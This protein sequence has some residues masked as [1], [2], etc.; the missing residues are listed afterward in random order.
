MLS[1]LK[2]NKAKPQDKPYKLTD[3]KGL[4]TA[5]RQALAV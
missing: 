4:K 5:R 2:I 3:G 1:D